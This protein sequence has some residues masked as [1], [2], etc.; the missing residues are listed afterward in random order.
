MLIPLLKTGTAADL[1][2]VCVPGLLMFMQLSK[3]GR[4]KQERD[5]EDGVN[6]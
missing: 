5:T 3:K 1:L 6:I 4:E 2:V